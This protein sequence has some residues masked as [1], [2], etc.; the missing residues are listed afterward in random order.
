MF[1][2]KRATY[3]DGGMVVG[4]RAEDLGTTDENDLIARKY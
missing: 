1:K 3:Q 2:R 4:G